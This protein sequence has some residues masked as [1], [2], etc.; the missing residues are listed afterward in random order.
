MFSSG[1]FSELIHNDL[2]HDLSINIYNNVTKSC[3]HS[4]VAISLVLPCVEVISW[5]I[6]QVEFSNKWILNQHQSPFRGY[7]TFNILSRKFLLEPEVSLF[8]EWVKMAM[9][10]VPPSM[11][12]K[13]GGFMIKSLRPWYQRCI[14]LLDWSIILE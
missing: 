7:Q 8:E 1:D 6:G 10:E 12:Q 5:L 11:L 4:I 3:L 13:N 2:E 9:Y 14:Q